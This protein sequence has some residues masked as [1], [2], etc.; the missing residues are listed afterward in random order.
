MKRTNR[1]QSLETR[2]KRSKSMMGK[3]HSSETK[4]KIS[5]ALKHYW[6]QIPSD[7]ENKSVT[8]NLNE[9]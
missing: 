2:L 6:E 4:K 9:E 5:N 1:K 3:K 7:D 8:V